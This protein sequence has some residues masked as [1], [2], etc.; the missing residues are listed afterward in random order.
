MVACFAQAGPPLPAASPL[1]HAPCARPA[2]T[3][4]AANKP[5]TVSSLRMIDRGGAG[6]VLQLLAD[7]NQSSCVAIQPDPSDPSDDPAAWG[8]RW[9]AGGWVDGRQLCL[10]CMRGRPRGGL[11]PPGRLAPAGWCAHLTPV[12]LHSAPPPLQPSLTWA[13]PRLWSLWRWR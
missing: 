1:N 4:A 13:I 2:E 11:R 10:V 9:L 12:P 5:V 7:N 3:N 8:E 6:S